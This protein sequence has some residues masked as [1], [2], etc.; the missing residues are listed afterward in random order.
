MKNNQESHQ[1][2]RRLA[3]AKIEE[4]GIDKLDAMPIQ[5]AQA[6]LRLA[7]HQMMQETGCHRQTARK[8]LASACRRART[9]GEPSPKW[10]GWRDQPRENGKFVARTRRT[11]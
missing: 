6:T 8:H 9:A 4:I 5:L 7:A 11:K 3:A 10:G 2:L 1:S